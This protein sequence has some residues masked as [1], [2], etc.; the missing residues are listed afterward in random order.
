[1]PLVRNILLDVPV[2]N[3]EGYVTGFGATS[4][5]PFIFPDLL[6]SMTQKVIPNEECHE[7]L[8]DNG[9][10][11]TSNHFCAMNRDTN[12]TSCTFDEGN[13]FIGENEGV[14]CVM[15]VLSFY[16]NMCRPQFPVVYTRLRGYHDWIWDQVLAWQ[17][18]E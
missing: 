5:E 1:M 6:Q 12:A 2:P 9:Q 4:T 13:G 8:G 3:S 11:V 16:I 10:L 7:L 15:G 14:Q 18:E 17:P